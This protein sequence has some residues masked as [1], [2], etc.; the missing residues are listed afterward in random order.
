MATSSCHSAR[1]LPPS[2]KDVLG[3]YT[4]IYPMQFYDAVR[5]QRRVAVRFPRDRERSTPCICGCVGRLQV[6]RAQFYTGC[7]S[8]CC[9]GVAQRRAPVLVCQR[10]RE[11][12]RAWAGVVAYVFD[13]L[14]VLRSLLSL[15]LGT[16]YSLWP[17]LNGRR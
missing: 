16:F 1:P 10:R 14:D 5:A 17:G 6:P 4:Y 7:Q 3:H 2:A 12:G 9:S 11:V 13:V 8:P 15:S